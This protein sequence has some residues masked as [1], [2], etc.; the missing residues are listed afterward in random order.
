MRNR[1]LGICMCAVMC[2]GLMAGCGGGG[3]SSGAAAGQ[4]SNAAGQSSNAVGQP[5]NVHEETV[6][7]VDRPV[8]AMFETNYQL[9]GKDHE[10]WIEQ[11]LNPAFKERTVYDELDRLREEPAMLSLVPVSWNGGRIL[12]LER[13]HEGEGPG[14][15]PY[16]LNNSIGFQKADG[17]RISSIDDDYKEKAISLRKTHPEYQG[18]FWCELRYAAQDNDDSYYQR[19]LYE[20]EGNE[21]VLTPVMNDFLDAE[22]GDILYMDGAEQERFQYEFKD[23]KMVLRQGDCEAALYHAMEAYQLEDEKRSDWLMRCEGVSRLGYETLEDIEYIRFSKGDAADH[24]RITSLELH[25]SDGTRLEANEKWDDNNLKPGS[26]IRAESYGNY[27]HITWDKKNSQKEGEETPG[28]L[29]FQYIDVSS[30]GSGVCGRYDG[31]I[32]VK[33]GK[34]Y[35][36]NSNYAYY[37]SRVANSFTEGAQELTETE[38]EKLLEKQQ[39]VIDK[40]RDA[41][42]NAGTTAQ[43][44]EESGIV[45]FDANILFDKGSADLT[46]D[47]AKTLDSF[48]EVYAAVMEEALAEGLIT[49][50]M[51]DGYADPDGD[52]DYNM[53]LSQRR[54]E[55]V[56][57]YCLEKAPSLGSVAKA[58]GHSYDNLILKEDGSIDADA[59][60]R[61]EFRFIL[62]MD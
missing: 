3:S 18:I 22:T 20:V 31:I 43:V 39:T 28:D 44:D 24:D 33:D 42:E 9:T 27:V 55:A 59:S 38:A 40:L 50:V 53:D 61:V 10:A 54:A 1:I 52:Y 49:N 34:V 16:G 25:F 51:I 11:M 5:Q 48:T 17:G 2:A 7:H 45:R 47:G 8:K 23:G 41:F 60:R 29:T 14:Y 19:Y 36:Y 30:G 21:L 26:S 46:E 13:V 15:I 12:D 58:E 57:A 37:Q 6:I 56:M 35:Q 62:K 4:S 32:L